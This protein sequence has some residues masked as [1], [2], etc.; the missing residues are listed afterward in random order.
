MFDIK[1]MKAALEA[2]EIDKKI[3]KEKNAAV[4]CMMNANYSSVRI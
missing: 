3:S 1:Q 2:L 4:T